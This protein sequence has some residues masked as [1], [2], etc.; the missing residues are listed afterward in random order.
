MVDR[1]DAII[2]KIKGLLAIANDQKSDEESQSAFILAQKLMMKH[3]IS[4]TEVEGRSDAPSIAD[5]QVT[6]H[7]KLFW[8]ERRLAQVISENFRVKFYYNNKILDNETQRKRAI[9]FLGFDNDIALAKEMYLLA[10]EAILFYSNRYVDSFYDDRTSRTRIHRITNGVKN[11]YMLGFLQGLEQKFEEQVKEMQQ[12]YG[13]IVLVPKEVAEEYDN[14]FDGTKGISF[15]LPPI[16][17]SFAYEKGF[18]EGNSIDYTKTTID[19]DIVGR[20]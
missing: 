12:E 20:H 10:Y 5:G 14:R 18:Y 1:N 19:D 6:V 11:S 8:W 13:L 17:E 4:M 7:K 15:K 9:Y 3:E 2:N 16:E